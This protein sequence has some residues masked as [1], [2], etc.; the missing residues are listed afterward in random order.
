MFCETFMNQ[1]QS[2]IGKLKSQNPAVSNLN[3]ENLIKS[4][5]CPTTTQAAKLVNKYITIMMRARKN[6]DEGL[7]MSNLT[8]P[9]HVENYSCPDTSLNESFSS[10]SGESL[11]SESILESDLD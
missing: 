11:S 5:L 1:R 10:S 3:S 8:F 7:H 6:I 4:M 9:P 2:F